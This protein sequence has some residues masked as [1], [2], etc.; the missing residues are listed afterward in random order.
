MRCIHPPESAPAGTYMAIHAVHRLERHHLG[1]SQAA[2]CALD[3]VAQQEWEHPQ[4]SAA[5]AAAAAEG[6]G[7]LAAMQER[8]VTARQQQE[9]RQG[10]QEQGRQQG[11]Q[12]GEQQVGQP[13]DDPSSSGGSSSNVIK[14][15]ALY[16]FLQGVL[17]L[18]RACSPCLRPGFSCNFRVAAWAGRR[19]RRCSLLTSPQPAMFHH[20]Y[21]FWPVPPAA[22]WTPTATASAACSAS[23][24]TTPCWRGWRGGWACCRWAC[25][26]A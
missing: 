14:V 24:R 26:G 12:Q 11:E 22:Q 10:G 2:A 20:G 1:S 17:Q 19:H 15:I 6:G 8:L 5:A 4:E 18:G 21:I 25:G 13:I 3:S 7:D 23:P 16:P 9:Q